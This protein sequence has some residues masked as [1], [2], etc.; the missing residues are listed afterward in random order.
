[1]F[2]EREHDVGRNSLA[3]ER[4]RSDIPGTLLRAGRLLYLLFNE[5]F[6]INSA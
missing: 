3:N 4:A 6:I 2:V 5:I 1:M